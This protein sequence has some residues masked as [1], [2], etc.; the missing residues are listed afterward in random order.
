M[1]TSSVSPRLRFFVSVIAL[2]LIGVAAWFWIRGRNTRTTDDAFVDSDIITVVSAAQGTVTSL[3]VTDNAHVQRGAR[4]LTLDAQDLKLTLD[5][6]QASKDAA[7]AQLNEVKA[8]GAAGAIHRASADAAVHLAEIKVAQAQLALSKAE[9]TAPA[10]G[11]VAH[12]S[13]SEGDSV[14]P[15]Q[16][17]LAI[18]GDHSWIIANL[19]ETQ[20]AHV[21]PGDAADIEIDAFPDLKLKGHVDSVQQGA[22]QSFSLLPPENASGNFV[23]VVQRVPVKIALDTHPNQPLPPG[24]SARVTIHVR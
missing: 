16:P 22:G 21:Q 9:V 24:L 8:A 7:D 2:A 11:T 20:L 18:V 12:R 13:V 1:Q 5:A 6:A 4:L 10:S 3:A 15:G 14:R 23:K 17:L 19:K